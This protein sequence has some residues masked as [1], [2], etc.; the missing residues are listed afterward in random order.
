MIS[1]DEL[2]AE[3]A[4]LDQQEEAAKIAVNAA[5]M[6]LEAVRGAKQMVAHLMKKAEEK[7]PKAA[8]EEKQ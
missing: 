4:G 1:R 5:T 6:Q 2:L 8:T 7:E 3:M